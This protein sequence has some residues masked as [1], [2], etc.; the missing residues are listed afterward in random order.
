MNK[1][2]ANSAIIAPIQFSLSIF[3]LKRVIAISIDVIM[4]PMLAKGYAIELSIT[5]KALIKN[6][7]EKKFGILNTNPYTKE[8]LLIP[9]SLKTNECIK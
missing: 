5:V 3:S 2:I 4:M 6:N 9:F 8:V 1:Y 7:N